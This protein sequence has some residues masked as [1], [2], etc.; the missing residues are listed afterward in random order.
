MTKEEAVSHVKENFD[1]QF[2]TSV[3]HPIQMSQMLLM[4]HR[5]VII[6]KKYLFQV[7]FSKFK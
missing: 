2:S 3:S 4:S 5:K 6:E 7:Y 1:L